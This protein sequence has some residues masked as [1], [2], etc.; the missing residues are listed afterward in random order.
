MKGEE[1]I[2][3][4]RMAFNPQT[5]GNHMR[6]RVGR[7]RAGQPAKSRQEDVLGCRLYLLHRRLD[8]IDLDKIQKF[9]GGMRAVISFW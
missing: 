9:F 6:K 3:P 7:A 1:E 4:A 2:I 5:I 8:R